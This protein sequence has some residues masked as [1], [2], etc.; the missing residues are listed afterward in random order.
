[1]MMIDNY[2]MVTNLD[3]SFV[4]SL[5]VGCLP[6]AGGKQPFKAMIKRRV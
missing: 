1:M 4:M 3:K 6:Y 2:Q 5:K